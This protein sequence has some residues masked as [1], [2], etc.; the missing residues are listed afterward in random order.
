MAVISCF[1]KVNLYDHTK[2]CSYSMQPRGQVNGLQ[3]SVLK[4]GELTYQ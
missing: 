2:A 1:K 4:A 3:N